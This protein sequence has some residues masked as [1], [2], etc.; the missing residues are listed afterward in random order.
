M[1]NES[2]T[3]PASGSLP[4]AGKH[5][6]EE[7]LRE[8]I[9]SIL[10]HEVDN[11]KSPFVKA[12]SDLM[13][14]KFEMP[15][16]KGIA[17]ELRLK[18]RSETFQQLRNWIAQQDFAKV[19]LSELAQ[20]VAALEDV[21]TQPDTEIQVPEN[22]KSSTDIRSVED[23][24]FYDDDEMPVAKPRKRL[25]QNKRPHEIL[26]ICLK[27]LMLIICLGAFSVGTVYYSANILAE[28]IME[29]STFKA[30]MSSIAETKIKQ[31]FGLPRSLPMNR[32]EM[33]NLY[34]GL[35]FDE[36]TLADEKG[37][38][39]LKVFLASNGQE[40]AAYDPASRLINDQWTR[41]IT[42][43]PRNLGTKDA[44]IQVLKEIGVWPKGESQ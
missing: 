11:E 40:I 29:T 33:I 15:L 5:K 43:N 20:R 16:A 34:P 27:C 12:L 18:I 37:N 13:F 25:F 22:S 19:D 30:A 7:K 42:I 44:R 17:S 6:N 23:F 8:I 24:S 26:E 32:S 21:L 36:I 39:Q 4:S 10:L 31:H 38:H 9:R 41:Q 3:T 1:G 2:N 14:L 35:I 28:R